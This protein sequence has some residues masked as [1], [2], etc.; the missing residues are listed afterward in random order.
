MHDILGMLGR[1]AFE[2]SEL[3]LQPVGD[4]HQHVEQRLVADVGLPARLDALDGGA[5]RVLVADFYGE[6]DREF[7]T[8][9][10]ADVP[11]L[12]AALRQAGGRAET[13]CERSGL[14]LAWVNH[15]LSSAEVNFGIGTKGVFG[16][17]WRCQL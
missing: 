17:D 4:G 2:G 5:E 16:P 8:A 10:R 15:L 12:V 9:A 11:A 14:D 13:R 6:A 3:G 7:Y 1:G